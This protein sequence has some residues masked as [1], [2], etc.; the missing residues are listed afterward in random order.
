MG[1]E[2]RAIYYIFVILKSW[3]SDTHTTWKEQPMGST[4]A[5]VTIKNPADHERSWEG[6]CRQQSP[7]GAVAAEGEA[8]G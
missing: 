8:D 3:P 6:E 1:C 7:R 5:T 2:L 4:H